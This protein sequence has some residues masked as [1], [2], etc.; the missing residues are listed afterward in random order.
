MAFVMKKLPT[1]RSFVLFLCTF[2]TPAKNLAKMLQ[3]FLFIILSYS[4][5]MRQQ[6]TAKYAQLSFPRKYLQFRFFWKYSAFKRILVIIRLF[7]NGLKLPQF[8]Y[9]MWQRLWSEKFD[10]VIEAVNLPPVQFGILSFFIYISFLRDYK[11]SQK[12]FQPLPGSLK[13]FF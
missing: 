6:V 13:A 2:K 9:L 3:N 4:L 11:S 7:S 5:V 10:V 1:E 8:E 12:N